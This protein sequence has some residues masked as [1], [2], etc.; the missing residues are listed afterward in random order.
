MNLCLRVT[1]P[2]TPSYA[3]DCGVNRDPTP[4]NSL[5][6]K[7]LKHERSYPADLGGRRRPMS[8]MGIPMTPSPEMAQRILRE[9][10]TLSKPFGTT[11]AIEGNVGVI[12]VAPTDG[13]G[14]EQ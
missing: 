2:L 13:Q 5:H 14:K 11:V 3:G 7:E 1:P 4:R 9:I 10:Q 6:H 12:H 8:R